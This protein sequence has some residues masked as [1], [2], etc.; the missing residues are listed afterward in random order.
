M[1]S[2]IYKEPTPAAVA[3]E[4]EGHTEANSQLRLKQDAANAAA[5]AAHAGATLNIAGEFAAGILLRMSMEERVVDRSTGDTRSV[6]VRAAANGL[7]AL[8][9]TL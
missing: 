3:V 1:K 8:G 4:R 5:L 9:T 2:G 7:S 6:V